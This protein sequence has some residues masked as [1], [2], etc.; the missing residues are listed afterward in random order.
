MTANSY[1]EKVRIVEVGPRDGLQ[2]HSVDVPTKTKIE[3]IQRLCAA[4]VGEIEITSFVRPDRVPQLADAAEVT[5]ALPQD[6]NTLYSALVPNRKGLESALSAGLSRISFFTAAS[7]TFNQKN[8]NATIGESLDRFRALLDAID[9][10][11]HVRAYISTCF[12]C[13]YE[14]DIDPQAV[15]EVVQKLLDLGVDELAI[16]DTIGVATPAGVDLLLDALEQ[17]VDL[18]DKIALHLH[19]TRGT[20]LANVYAALLR[21][22][23]NFDSA[24][25]GLGGCPFAP[26]AS[27]NL[28]TEDL[29]YLLHGLGI[30]TGVDLDQLIETSL[31]F[32]RELGT[33]LP[34]R[35]L[36]TFRARST[37]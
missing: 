18:T 28:S 11:T 32:E 7:E 16:S 31:W 29:V 20:A 33:S 10:Q 35:V 4:G 25:G 9:H 22:V 37:K 8:T 2:N 23:V 26:G 13:P 24:A 34:S 36:S 14:G 17:C 3:W 19:D 21:G 15:V 6:Q 30:E 5:A 27:G 1:P 12:G